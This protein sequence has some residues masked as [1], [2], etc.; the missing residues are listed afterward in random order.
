MNWSFYKSSHFSKELHVPAFTYTGVIVQGQDLVLS[1]DTHLCDCGQVAQPPWLL[2]S[3]FVKWR[4]TDSAF[5]LEPGIWNVLKESN[6]KS[7][8]CL[9]SALN[10][11]PCLHP[12]FP[13]LQLWALLPLSGVWR[14]CNLSSA[15]PSALLHQGF[16]SF[17]LQMQPLAAS[18][19]I[20]LSVEQRY[21]GAAR[22][23]HTYIEQFLVQKWYCLL[24]SKLG[25]EPYCHLF[26]HLLLYDF[27]FLQN[28]LFL[29]CQL[30]TIS[31]LF[32]FFPSLYIQA[33]FFLFCCTNEIIVY[34]LF[35]E[36]LHA[37]RQI[38]ALK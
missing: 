5:S 17:F 37:F 25:S 23:L 30:F 33:Y 27:F 32:R 11:Y 15:C 24:S 7:W 26:S 6:S 1:L 12:C 22:T 18:C 4:C 10:R 19:A 34:I 35:C 28:A 36:L 8:L 21:L 16:P 38:P 2:L 3:S 20:Y 29:K 13:L 14:N 31:H 9:S